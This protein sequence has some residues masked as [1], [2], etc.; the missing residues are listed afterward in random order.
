[1]TC[2]YMHKLCKSGCDNHVCRAFFPEKQPLI[3]KGSKDICRGDIYETECLQYEA[4]VEWR[5]ERRIKGLTEKCFFARNTR[6]GRPWEWWCKG[7]QTPFLLTTYE[8]REG[9]DDIPVRDENGEIRFIKSIDDIKGICLSGDASI[10]I[11]CPNYKVGM[12]LR[13]L[14]KTLKTKKTKDIVI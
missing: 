6:C 9:T 11:E 10:Y 14:A 13:E 4:G 8:I 5:E 12:E 7:G 2:Q 1:M 3:Q